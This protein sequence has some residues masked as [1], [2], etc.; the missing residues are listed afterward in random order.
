VPKIS[1][2]HFKPDEYEWLRKTF[3][4]RSRDLKKESER[5]QKKRG[6]QAIFSLYK[7][8]CAPVISEYLKETIMLDLQRQDIRNIQAA[9]RQ[10]LEACMDKTI[11]EYQRRLTEYAADAERF[12]AYLERAKQ[13]A[14][15]LAALLTKVE[16]EL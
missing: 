9:T 14:S 6:A 16:R 12:R 13:H 8:I 10:Q 15:F 5:L 2:V 1:R 7:K 3:D 4:I 11:P